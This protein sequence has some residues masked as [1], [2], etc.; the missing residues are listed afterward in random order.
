MTWNR[1]AFL[2]CLLFFGPH[3]SAQTSQN[4]GS[5]DLAIALPMAFRDVP[6]DPFFLR[7]WYQTLSQSFSQTSVGS[8]LDSESRY[9]DWQL[10]SLHIAPC[11]PLGQ[12]PQNAE[13]NC[14]PDI[15]LV[16]QAVQ[17]KIRLHE[18][19]MENAGDDRAVHALY[20]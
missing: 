2:T 7:T 20:P 10:V 4:L 6:R 1:L 14:W 13:Q 12:T 17:R 11:A 15:R 18:S 16:W 3:L 9:T 19:Y 8:A 5:K